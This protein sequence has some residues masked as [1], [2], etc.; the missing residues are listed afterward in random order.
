M[1]TYS[2]APDKRDHLNYLE[3]KLRNKCSIFVNTFKTIQGFRRDNFV[4]ES[5]FR[6]NSKFVSDAILMY[7]AFHSSIA[8]FTSG[9]SYHQNVLKKYV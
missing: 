2:D 8:S 4:S 6:D 1:S 3:E 5:Y 7:C 9:S